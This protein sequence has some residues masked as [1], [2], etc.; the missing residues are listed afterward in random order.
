MK[1]PALQNRRVAVFEW[2][3]GPE[4]FPGLSRNGPLASKEKELIS[5]TY[6]AASNSNMTNCRNQ[7]GM[8]GINMHYFPKDKTLQQ[9]WIRFVLIHRISANVSLHGQ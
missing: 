1:R 2:L 4:K 8:P 9:K 5:V 3:F 7:T 6:C